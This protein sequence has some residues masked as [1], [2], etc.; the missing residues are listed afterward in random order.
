MAASVASLIENYISGFDDSASK[1]V[2]NDLTSG[3]TSL[4]SIVENLGPFLTNKETNVR[5][6]ATRLIADILHNI[7]RDFF[8]DKEVGLLCTYLCERL[9]DHHSLQPHALFGILALSKSSHL[10]SGAI[11]AICRTVFKEVHCQSLAQADRRTV[12]NLFLTLLTTR[13]EDVQKLGADFVYGYLQ[14]MDTEKDPRNLVLAFTCARVV[15]QNLPLGVFVEEMFEVVSCYFPIDF[16]PSAADPSGISKEDLIFSLRGCLAATPKFAQF[17]LPLLM[18]KLTSDLKSAKIDSLQ[19][20]AEC[21]KSYGAENLYEFQ[22]SFF[23]CIKKEIFLSSDPAIEEAGLSALQSMVA[24]IAS[25]ITQSDRKK[26][27]DGFVDEI[28]NDCKGHLLQP[29]LMLMLSTGRILQAV[30]LGSELACA[31]IVRSAVPLLVEA[32]NK[33]TQTT[34]KHNVII[35]LNGFLGVTASFS[36]TNKNPNPMISAYKT[37]LLDLYKRSVEDENNSIQ[38]LG[39]RGYR[40]ISMAT[41]DNLTTEDISNIAQQLVN[42]VVENSFEINTRHECCEVLQLIMSQYPDIAETV[43][44]PR[45]FNILHNEPMSVDGSSQLDKTGVL[46]VLPP[47]TRGQMCLKLVTDVLYKMLN[48]PDFIELYCPLSK[49]LAKLS[50]ACSP[51]TDCTNTLT[52]GVRIVHDLVTSKCRCARWYQALCGDLVLANLAEFIRHEACHWTES[53]ILEMQ[54]LF[55]DSYLPSTTCDTEYKGDDLDLFKGQPAS[56]SPLQASCDAVFVCLLTPVMCSSPPQFLS[57]TA[58][59]SDLLD[60]LAALVFEDLSAN[61]HVHVCKCLAGMLNKL[62]QGESLQTVLCTLK[63]KI[64]AKLENESDTHSV[65]TLSWVTKALVLRG[66][67]MAG[68][69]V[70]MLIQTLSSTA[71]GRQAARGFQTVLSMY[72]EVLNRQMHASV[73]MMYRQRFFLEHLGPIVTAYGSALQES[74]KNYLLAL[75]YMMQGLDKQVIIPEMNKI[76]PLLIQ[77]LLQDDLDLQLVTMETLSELLC[78][79]PSVVAKQIDSLVPQLLSLTTYKP[80]MK[81]RISALKCLKELTTL[82]SHVLVPYQNKVCRAL[83]PVLD[84]MKRLVRAQA[85]VAR[86]EWILLD[87]DKQ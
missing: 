28:L 80:S 74:K 72:E 33:H 20:L 3:S 82:P 54:S 14:A 61:A 78:S 52:A 36:Y 84:D 55:I 42:K 18:E 23:S 47:I 19:T 53:K 70:S 46:E 4:S 68:D 13:L 67:S 35:V 65:V 64:Q 21:A 63:D 10:T 77:S 69:F 71:N 83:V 7:P 15:I 16:S 45:F 30:A 86:Q 38:L 34:P 87:S 24:A 32:Y 85:V 43:V 62:Q 50:E 66:H 6:R 75:S 59:L 39:I 26:S 73:R 11:E 60:R 27:L 1:S 57:K 37:H 79:A 22:T 81:V 58:R 5:A 41:G 29:E 12:Y 2:A 25:G 31:Q 76:Y 17:C 51:D 40:S 48:N 44:Y 8:N 56:F 49:C 9:V